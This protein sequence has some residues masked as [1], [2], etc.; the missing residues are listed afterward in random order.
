MRLLNPLPP[1]PYNA[2]GLT[3]GFSFF[4]NLIRSLFPTEFDVEVYLFYDPE[5]SKKMTSIYT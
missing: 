1:S 2:A 4:I 5:N 3:F